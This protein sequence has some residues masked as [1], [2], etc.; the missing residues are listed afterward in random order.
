MPKREVSGVVDAPFRQSVKYENS[1]VD[2]NS[3]GLVGLAQIGSPR[4]GNAPEE[5]KK[6]RERNAWQRQG[7]RT[8][9]LRRIGP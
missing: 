3:D 1:S 4:R 9:V 7:Y 2:L 8:D 5:T 6:G